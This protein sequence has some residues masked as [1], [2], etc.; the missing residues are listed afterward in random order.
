MAKKKTKLDLNNARDFLQ[1]VLQA[2]DNHG[3]ESEP[4]MEA[5]DLQLFAMALWEALPSET[6]MR[7]M[8]SR[9]WRDFIYDHNGATLPKNDE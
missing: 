3:N 8:A 5:G 1:A 4:D 7:F 2:A 9:E 6:Q